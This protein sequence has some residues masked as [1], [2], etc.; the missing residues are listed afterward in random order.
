V[1]LEKQCEWKRGSEILRSKIMAPVERAPS[2]GP[3]PTN[4]SAPNMQFRGIR[5][6]AIGVAEM[7]CGSK[8]SNPPFP[9]P[10]GA[11]R[12]GAGSPHA[13]ARCLP[14]KK[15]WHA[16]L[17]PA[18]PTRGLLPPCASPAEQRGRTWKK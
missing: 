3:E 10:P 9:F 17:L 1:R 11:S 4:A 7:A 5:P 12:G 2:D 18:P 16:S 6:L 8:E 13:E 14:A 15:R